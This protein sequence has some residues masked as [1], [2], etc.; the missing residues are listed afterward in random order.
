MAI[1]VVNEDTTSYLTIQFFDKTG[2]AATPASISYRVDCLTNGR[3]VRAWTSFPG[4]PASS[5][6]LTLTPGD[7]AILSP[8]NG[9]ERR[10]IQIVAS[11]GADDQYH[12]EFVYDVEN[13]REPIAP[14]LVRG[15]DYSQADG[16][17]LKFTGGLG[18][19]DLSGATAQFLATSTSVAT[20]LLVAAT[21]EAPSGTN[22]VVRLELS[23]AETAAL[24]PAANYRYKLTATLTSGRVV[25]LMSGKLAIVER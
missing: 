20:T 6:E 21:I 17:A 13:L 5:I 16:R 14:V 15:D 18:W 25:T 23:A 11:Y 3:E 7:N 8:Q 4:T 12:G 19:P 2:A 22:K 24:E 9:S 10:V 1:E